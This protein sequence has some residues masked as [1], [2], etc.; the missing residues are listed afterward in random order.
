MH[1]FIDGRNDAIIAN[2][3]K[4][5][6]KVFPVLPVLWVD[7]PELTLITYKKNGTMEA[8]NCIRYG[9]AKTIR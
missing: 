5:L 2:K 4:I 9:G 3:R 7:V 1:C 8:L 6:C